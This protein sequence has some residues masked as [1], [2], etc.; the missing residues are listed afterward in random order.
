MLVGGFTQI[1][2]ASIVLG[3]NNNVNH[4]ISDVERP[5]Y[6]QLNCD[7]TCYLSLSSSREREM[8]IQHEKI[9]KGAPFPCHHKVGN[10]IHVCHEPL[11]CILITHEI[12]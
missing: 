6:S 12:V 3:I 11:R 9:K 1:S 5:L 8:Y 7:S 2:L 4:I 10:Y